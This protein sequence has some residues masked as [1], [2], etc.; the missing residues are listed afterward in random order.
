MIILII[1]KND[2]SYHLKERK[3]SYEYEYIDTTNE[4]DDDFGVK[5][6]GGGFQ[7]D[8]DKR[9]KRRPDTDYTAW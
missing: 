4:F 9:F 8:E 2:Y 6:F 1:L 3:L 5:D 7:R